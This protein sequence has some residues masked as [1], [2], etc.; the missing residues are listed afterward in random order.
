MPPSTNG[1]RRSPR[2]RTVVGTAQ[3]QYWGPLLVPVPGNDHWFSATSASAVSLWVFSISEWSFLRSPCLLDQTL[4]TSPQGHIWAVVV[5]PMFPASL[6]TLI[7]GEKNIHFLQIYNLPNLFYWNCK[8]GDR[9]R[10]RIINQPL[11]FI[12]NIVC[13]YFQELI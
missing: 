2:Q 6:R 4:G 8:T 7:I 13:P 11:P 3:H 1:R 10:Y 9:S 5:V 12:F